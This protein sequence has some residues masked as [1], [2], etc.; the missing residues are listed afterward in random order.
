MCTVNLMRNVAISDLIGDIYL[1][2]FL[3]LYYE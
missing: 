3:T 1:V 2:V